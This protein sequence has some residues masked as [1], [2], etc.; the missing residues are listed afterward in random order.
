MFSTTHCVPHGEGLN[1]RL[2]ARNELKQHRCIVGPG[3]AWAESIIPCR[4]GCHIPEIGQAVSW[5]TDAV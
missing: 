2:R 1:S 4:L 3:M 5:A